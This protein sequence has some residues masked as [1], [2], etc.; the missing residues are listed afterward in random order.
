MIVAMAGGQQ[1][2]LTLDP[3][4]PAATITT[5]IVGVAKGDVPHDGMAY[6]SIFAAGL[7]LFVLILLTNITGQVLRR[8]TRAHRSV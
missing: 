1:P 2:N 3:T 7:A 6:R 5:Y 4:Q 8:A